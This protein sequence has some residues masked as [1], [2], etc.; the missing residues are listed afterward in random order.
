MDKLLK[1][2]KVWGNTICFTLLT[3]FSHLLP[4]TVDKTIATHTK[5]YKKPYKQ[6]V[7]IYPNVG[8]IVIIF[9]AYQT[10]REFENRR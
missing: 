1:Q 10:L 5:G 4:L 9:T 8:A 3:G 2:K 6:K 7:N